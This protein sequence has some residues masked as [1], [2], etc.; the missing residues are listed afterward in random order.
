MQTVAEAL[1]RWSPP[2]RPTFD[3][4]L[5]P[6]RYALDF[7]TGAGH[8]VIPEEIRYRVDRKVM[9]KPNAKGEA[10]KRR[11]PADFMARL[12]LMAWVEETGED[13]EAVYAALADR[14]LEAQGIERS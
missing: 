10:R 7:L 11:H 8:S 1:A 5:Y 2:S 13:E 14:H 9:S 6:Y 3:P 4:T 12:M